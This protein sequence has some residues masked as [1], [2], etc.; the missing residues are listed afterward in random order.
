M[1]GGKEWSCSFFVFLGAHRSS[2]WRQSMVQPPGYVGVLSRGCR[3]EHLGASVRAHCGL[4]VVG[5]V[6]P[7]S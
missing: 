6:L 4:P 2:V 1:E 3:C 5:G 7:P